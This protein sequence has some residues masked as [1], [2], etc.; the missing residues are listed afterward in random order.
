MAWS[1]LEAR[2]IVPA[3]NIGKCRHQLGEGG[4]DEDAS[5]HSQSIIVA[6]AADKTHLRRRPSRR[7]VAIRGYAD[8][9]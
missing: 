4:F 2:K 6:D 3:P 9:V 5:T 8:P 7:A 1:L